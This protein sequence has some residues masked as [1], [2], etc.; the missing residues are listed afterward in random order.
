MVVAFL[1]RSQMHHRPPRRRCPLALAPTTCRAALTLARIRQRA[2]PPTVISYCK[3]V[4]RSVAEVNRPQIK[5]LLEIVLGV[6]SLFGFG[7]FLLVRRLRT[8]RNYWPE[9]GVRMPAYPPMFPW[10]NSAVLLK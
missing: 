1:R 7:A 8:M 5:M 4:F 9:K 3:C 10:G 6:V 2:H